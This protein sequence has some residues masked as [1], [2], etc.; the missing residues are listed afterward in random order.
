M[1]RE[2]TENLP[3]GIKCSLHRRSQRGGLRGL[4][5][6]SNEKNIK[7]SLLNLTLNM[8]YKNDK[9]ISNLSSPDSFFQAQNAPKSVFGRGSAPDPAEGAYDASPDPLVG[10]RGGYPLSIPLP[11]RRL[12]R[13]ELG[14]YGASVPRP[15]Q[16]KILATPV[17]VSSI[18][19]PRQTL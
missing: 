4:S 11:A 16:H 13:L 6:P 12:R 7:A 3:M 2:P 1:K 14:A 10:W 15:P 9:K 18:F 5:P 17:A 8:R 19:S